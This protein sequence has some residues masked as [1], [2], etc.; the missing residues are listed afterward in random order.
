MGRPRLA[1]TLG[2][3]RGI[4]PEIAARAVR[5][6]EPIAADVV[7]IGPEGVGI[8]PDVDLMPVGRWS[9][10]D[11]ASAAGR[12]S[13][14]AVERAVA[15]VSSGEVDAIVTA[16]IF[17]PALA[18]AGYPWAGHTEMLRDLVGTP[19]TALCL[20]AERTRL[21]SPLRVVLATGHVPLRSV[22]RLYTI[23]VLCSVGHLTH[24]GLRRWWGVERPRLAV[25]AINPHA[26][27]SGLFGD[28]ESRVCEP[29][30]ARLLAEGLRVDGPYP[31]DTVFLRAMK[32]EADA[33][34]APY[35]DVGMAA[36]KTACFGA[37]VNVTLGLP[38]PR[39][40]PDHGTAFDIAG[41]GKADPASMRA[42]LELALSFV[43]RILTSKTESNRLAGR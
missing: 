31:A 27:D 30:I 41:T 1:I 40:S 18:A 29:A 24:D 8:A 33:V 37:G 22:P 43:G 10:T 39:T 7:L 23:D 3:P 12:L 16:P 5:E 35:H 28:E 32:G 34:I 14:L 15:L 25:C 11:P 17:K 6:P 21:G 26:S 2:D 13:V 42:A 19:K 4:G 36:I 20:S 38:F 9:A